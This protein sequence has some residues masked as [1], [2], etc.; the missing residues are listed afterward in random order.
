MSNRSNKMLS[1]I[2][3]TVALACALLLTSQ[4]LQAAVGIGVSINIAPPELPVY[5]Q[6]PVPGPGYIWTPGYWAW[7]DSDY[8]WVPGTWVEA[9]EPGY[10]WTPGYW[11][12]NDGL[13]VWNGGYW[14][15]HIGFYGGV[16]YGFGYTGQGYAGGYWDHGA[17]RYNSA[18][19]NIHN[20]VHITNVYN[21]TVVVNNDNRVSFNGGHG[22]IQARPG[23]NEMAAEHDH[24]LTPVEAQVHHEEGA[25]ANPELRA[26]ENHGHPPIA[27][28]P[29]AGVFAG[30]GVTPSRGPEASHVTTFSGGAPQ[31]GSANTGV[32]AHDRPAAGTLPA[33]AA[34]QSHAE[35]GMGPAAPAHTNVTPPPHSPTPT[36]GAPTHNAVPGGNVQHG[37]APAGAGHPA[38]SGAPA[39]AG[40]PAGG[41]A[42]AGGG[43]PGGAGPPHPQHE[44][45][46][47]PEQPEHDRPH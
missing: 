26:S 9:P 31:H 10:L 14:G 1:G 39:G 29:R 22:G 8:Y 6:P 34:P 18:Y 37:G 21:R 44:A 20:N 13:Y 12:W 2:F 45:H 23:A 11:G 28:T 7:G 42:P 24:H 47:Q 33:A 38:G 30:Q 35:S 27:A 36:G 25:R 15:P 46:Q 17:F 4:V 19:N 40:H 43:H 41:G 32:Q 5:E 16:N 3:Y